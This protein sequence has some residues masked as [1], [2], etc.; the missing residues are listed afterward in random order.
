[1]DQ[2]SRGSPGLVPAGVLDRADASPA[3]WKLEPS[4]PIVYYW[5]RF[6]HK[7]A[8]THNVDVRPVVVWKPGPLR[9]FF[10]LVLHNTLYSSLYPTSSLRQGYS[11]LAKVFLG[12]GLPVRRGLT[13]WIVEDPGFGVIADPEAPAHT[14]VGF[15]E[16]GFLFNRAFVGL[17]KRFPHG[18]TLDLRYLYERSYR[19]DRVLKAQNHYLFVRVRYMVKVP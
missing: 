2:E 6:P 5:M 13:L 14:G 19:P 3:P 11:L 17:E 8:Y 10:G 4:L 1:M 7:S 16:K 12:I 18:W 9:G 15:T